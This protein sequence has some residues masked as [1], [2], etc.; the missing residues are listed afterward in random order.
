MQQ[1]SITLLEFQNRITKSIQKDDLKE[2]WIRCEIT[3]FNNPNHVYIE[4]TQTE[5]N[6]MVA[7]QKAMI[8]A[9]KK[10]FILNKFLTGT[11]TPLQKDI[12]V[13][14]RVTAKNSPVHG[15]SLD[16]IDIEPSFT[17]GK[18][19]LKIQE[20]EN[21]LL[22][23]GV[24]DKNK[25]FQVPEYFTNVAVL[26]PKG[27]AGEGDFK[28][29]ADLLEE[30]SLCKFT[31]FFATM[32]G[33]QAE[34]SISKQIAEINRAHAE[35]NFDALIII[36]GGGAIADLSWLN[37]FKSANYICHSK[38][39]VFCGLGHDRDISILCKVANLNLG[40]PS[41]CINF[42][43]K[44]NIKSIEIAK[45]NLLRLESQFINRRSQITSMAELSINQ[46]RTM[47]LNN[48]QNAVTARENKHNTLYRTFKSGVIN[49]K[50][51]INKSN[52]SLNDTYSKSIARVI[53]NTLRQENEL[54]KMFNLSVKH[55]SARS[56][57]LKNTLDNLMKMAP[58]K[59]ME[60][61]FTAQF[62]ANQTSKQKINEAKLAKE[63]K[64]QN[65]KNLFSN[66]VTKESSYA[67]TTQLS[68]QYTYSSFYKNIKALVKS[69]HD[70]IFMMQPKRVL[71]KGFALIRNPKG[72][73]ITK[74][75]QIQENDSILIEFQD[76]TLKAKIGNQDAKK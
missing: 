74:A 58:V 39:P 16:I 10:D 14:I 38:L 7:K 53:T 37:N 48:V 64:W 23:K 51:M 73:V 76:N 54:E 24:F 11:G 41:K 42:I 25:S 70:N 67:V 20:I 33:L 26:T 2:V 55:R 3:D 52:R 40:T 35:Q 44:S 57:E 71:E 19:Q 21:A 66:K 34:D 5:N 15:I 12:D 75:T 65:L 17:V 68:W 43:T 60:K 36:R 50:G 22:A 72:K 47:Y 29:E 59:L 4:L 27:S 49:C 8:W 62:R 56:I 63:N 30:V 69:M 6:R 31:Y 45:Q 46:L 32:Q 61:I 9:N 1:E 13:L 28:K 18:L